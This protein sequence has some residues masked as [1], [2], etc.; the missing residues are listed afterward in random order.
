MLQSGIGVVVVEG[1]G[2]GPPTRQV[3]RPPGGLIMVSEDDVPSG[4]AP[5]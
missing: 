5:P 1:V 3:D 4:P 2:G